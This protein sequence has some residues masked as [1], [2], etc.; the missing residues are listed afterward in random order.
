[1][2]FHIDDSHKAVRCAESIS[3]K[4]R[5]HAWRAYPT[6]AVG[7]VVGGKYVEL[8]NIAALPGTSFVVDTY[9]DD[10]DAI[11]HSHPDMPPHPSAADMR[12]QWA[13]SVPWGVV[14]VDGQTAQT[15][16]V[17][18]FGDKCPIP[19]LVGRT[20]LSGV[21]DCWCLI[22]DWYRQNYPDIGDRMPQLARDFDWYRKG[23]DLLC[24]ENI[25]KAGFRI[26]DNR[27]D[28]HVGDIVMGRIASRVVNHCGILIQG[29][30]VLSHTEGRLSRREVVGPW[31]RR[32]EYILRHRSLT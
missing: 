24:R 13:M 23:E 22:R 4:V 16:E 2:Q 19:P 9:P 3:R 10:V 1:M 12:Q 11:T 32:A 29:G 17:E 30:L 25:S 7:C 15:T 20:F 26:V 27:S 6:E 18:W 21:R 14:G 28:L 31:I 8:K 5:E